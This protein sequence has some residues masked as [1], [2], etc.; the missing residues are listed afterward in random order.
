LATSAKTPIANSNRL[1]GGTGDLAKAV[2]RDNAAR[3]SGLL[4][5]I[6]QLD[7]LLQFFGEAPE[8]VKKSAAEFRDAL[9]EWSD[10]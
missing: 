3:K 4:Q 8:R 9:K 5:A 1:E 7:M 6:S 10:S 2:G